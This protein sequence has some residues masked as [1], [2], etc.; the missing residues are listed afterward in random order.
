GRLLSDPTFFRYAMYLYNH[1]TARFVHYHH[2]LIPII[3]GC[4]MMM[5]TPTTPTGTAPQ[6]L[7]TPQSA[8]PPA[9]ETIIGPPPVIQTFGFPPGP[10]INLTVPAPPSVVLLALGMGGLASRLRR[11]R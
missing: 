11:R 1:N 10:P 6:T 5:M 8:P 3:R 4:A 2:S 7:V 9:G